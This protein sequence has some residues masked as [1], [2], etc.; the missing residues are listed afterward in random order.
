MPLIRYCTVRAKP[1]SCQRLSITPHTVFSNCPLITYCHTTHEGLNGGWCRIVINESLYSH[2]SAELR[3]H[4]RIRGR[5]NKTSNVATSSY[6][7]LT[8][9]FSLMIDSIVNSGYSKKAFVPTFR[10]EVEKA[11]SAAFSDHFAGDNDLYLASAVEDFLNY[12]I[13]RCAG[14]ARPGRCLGGLYEQ[15]DKSVYGNRESVVTV[16][17]IFEQC[18]PITDSRVLFFASGLCLSLIT[19]SQSAIGLRIVGIAD[20]AVPYFE[21]SSSLHGRDAGRRSIICLLFIAAFFPKT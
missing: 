6:R 15:F 3:D 16:F 11:I 14:A 8:T 21:I 20:R 5:R 13:P 10:A 12:A 7:T 1:C 4:S 18:F 17:A 2:K 9:S 19:T